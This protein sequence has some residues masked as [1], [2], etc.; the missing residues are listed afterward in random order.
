MS[1]SKSLSHGAILVRNF[2]AAMISDGAI[3]QYDVTMVTL[4]WMLTWLHYSAVNVLL[5]VL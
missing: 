5:E 2:A 1:A 4:N 3:V